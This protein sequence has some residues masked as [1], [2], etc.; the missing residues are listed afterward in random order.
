MHERAGQSRYF[1]ATDTPSFFKGGA[2]E[3]NSTVLLVDRMLFVR[4]V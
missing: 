1:S 3:S 2:V 4:L